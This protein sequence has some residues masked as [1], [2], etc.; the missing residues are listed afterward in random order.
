M[1]EALPDIGTVAFIL[2]WMFTTFAGYFL[3]RV[4]FT[5][6]EPREIIL[7]SAFYWLM[8]VLRQLCA[9]VMFASGSWSI[10]YMVIDLTGMITWL[11][12][13][14]VATIRTQ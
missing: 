12:V 1:S 10:L 8:M 4:I 9:I 11:V 7:V 13:Y 14:V 2:H 6:K 5:T 3:V